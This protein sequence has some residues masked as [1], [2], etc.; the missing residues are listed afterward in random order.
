MARIIAGEA[1]SLPLDV[2]QGPTRPTSDR[3]REA[4]FSALASRIDFT[5]LRVLD[6][7]AGSGALGLEALSRGAS[8]L[9]AVD[10][11]KAACTVIRTN[12]ARL[13]KALAHPVSIEVRCQSVQTALS[14]MPPEATMDLVF[15]DP[16]YEQP[17]E[18]ITEILDALGPLIHPEATIVVERSTRTP[19]PHWPERLTLVGTKTYGDT[20][21]FTLSR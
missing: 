4:M 3:V 9:T 14:S 20:R 8:R 5:G 21:V 16:P 1:G 19:E 12:S 13:E 15:I 7:F 17:S 11:N 10:S 18:E 2:P 6:L